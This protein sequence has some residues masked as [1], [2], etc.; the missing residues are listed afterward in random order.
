MRAL[1]VLPGPEF[2]VKDVADGWCSGLA[3]CGVE[4][5]TYDLG[6]ALAFY[7]Q[8][9][10][11]HGQEND[12]L[13]AAD[14]AARG[15][16]A[17][18]YDFW[19]DVV[20][21]VSAFFIPPDC[22]KLIRA[23]GH[24]LVSLLTESPYEDDNQLGVAAASDLVLVNDPTNLERFR[25][26]NPQTY[27][28]PHAYDPARH[29]PR[30]ITEPDLLSDFCFVGTAYPSRLDFLEAVDWSGIDVALGGNFTHV[31][32]SSPVLKF[33]A[34]DHDVCCP[35]DQATLLYAGTK[36]SANL[37]RVEAQRPGLSEGWA[38]GPREVELAACGTFYLTQP[39]GENREVL[40]MLPIFDG[41]A[42]FGEQLRWWLA[43][44]DE[45]SAV[46]E[47]ARAAISDRTFANHAAHLLG[48]L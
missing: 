35:N 39:R 9:P 32:E 1:V 24:K 48:R 46:A 44:P 12:G 8:H 3:R 38:M 23:R 31:P 43:H 19:P 40:P 34:H 17:V 33:L 47:Q 41:P 14:M 10:T 11:I 26:V 13:I 21:I 22:F 36:A 45:R 4:V 7:T 42:D 30:R 27:Y 20:L 29:F 28:Q 18:L 6:A 25:E 5:K 37:Y 16:R 15:L 2:S